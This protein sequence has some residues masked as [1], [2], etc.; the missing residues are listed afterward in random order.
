MPSPDD[1]DATATAVNDPDETSP[2]ACEDSL[3][4]LE[5]IEREAKGQRLDLAAGPTRLGRYVLLREIGAGAIGVVYAAYHE[6]LDRKLA[7]KVLNRQRAG[8]VDLEA[9]LQREARALAKLSHP[10][11]VQVYDVGKFEGR[12]FVAME[13]VEGETLS[14]WLRR[15]NTLAEKLAMFIAAGRGL[16][17]AHQAG[18]VH[19]DFK[20]DNVLV[21]HDG[22]PRVLDFGLARA[23]EYIPPPRPVQSTPRQTTGAL[24][25]IAQFL[26]TGPVAALRSSRTGASDPE[27]TV[28]SPEPRL[29]RPVPLPKELPEGNLATADP[30]ADAA[31]D[32]SRVLA[33]GEDVHAAETQVDGDPEY[34]ATIMSEPGLHISVAADN[35]SVV[36]D[37]VTRDGALLG[38][39]AYMSPEQFLGQRVDHFSD[40]F[41]FCVALYE[42]LYGQR[43][44]SG[45]NTMELALQTQ[46]GSV[47][48]PPPNSEVPT[49][50]RQIVLRGLSPRAANRYE[51]MEALLAELEYDPTQHRRGRWIVGIGVAAVAVLA[52]AIGTLGPKQAPA[53]PTVDTVTD[54]LWPSSRAV[55]LGEAFARSRLL[56]ANAAWTGAEQRLV[57]W[58]SAWARERVDACEAT[59]V[60]Q[61]FSAEVLDLRQACLD[62]GR[63]AFEALTEQF[64]SG[65]ATVIER[66]IE[67]AAELPDPRRCSD[68]N[69]LLTGVEA[70]PET[71]AVE[72]GD[73]R[74]HLAEI[75]M[76]GNTGRWQQGLALAEQAVE[77][78]RGTRYGP[79]LAEALLVHGRLLA[80]SR[81]GDE[82]LAALQTA[83]DEAERNAHDELVP[84]VATE[85][86]SLSIYTR[87]DPIRGRIWAR[88]AMT[89]LDRVQGD[90]HARA[91]GLRALGNIERLDGENAQAEAHL[92][93]ALELLD[94]HSAGHPDRAI[95]L[96]DLGNTLYDQGRFDA[97]GEAYE[98]ALTQSIQSFGANHPRVG[99]AHY[100]LARVALAQ[101]NFDEVRT[102]NEQ[103]R[104][105]YEAAYGP[106]HRDVGKV[107]LLAANAAVAAGELADAVVHARRVKDIYDVEFA[108]DSLD[109]AEPDLV[110]GHIAFAT[111][112]YDEALTHY[113]GCLATQRAALPPGHI[114]MA[115][116]LTNIGLVHLSLDEPDPAVDNLGEAVVLLEA[117][118]L[119]D[120]EE[121]RLARHYLGDALLARAGAGDFR[122][123]AL[124]FETAFEGCTEPPM[125]A[126]LA[127]RAARAHGLQ[128]DTAAAVRW[129]DRARPLFLTLDPKQHPEQP[130]ALAE[131][132]ELSQ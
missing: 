40:Q 116:T 5:R 73:L 13:F 131:L 71:V 112:Q 24:A 126:G 111:K 122:R 46:E 83:L 55:A 30:G 28:S 61:E 23:A 11:V 130:A 54:E 78:A 118:E 120:P 41:S 106:R 96:N 90:G 66:A 103:A 98:Q 16:A 34:A 45:K 53:C 70:P 6:E 59:H 48:D 97:A 43:P 47:A 33:T 7:I 85:L 17:A 38:T 84:R 4:G 1:I 68:V 60:R 67:A 65:E 69:A 89:A 12:V 72:V 95:M 19:R 109:R 26:N 87:P 94:E 108:P 115:L 62:R 50:L 81:A 107:E 77:Q 49:R 76:L 2:D 82:A 3:G 129:A 56:Y 21:G 132:D 14:D 20:P 63:R 9:R 91:R 57:A 101:A 35:N 52:F 99:H 37:V 124:Q 31:L 27:R 121:L 113:R 123:A 114:Q 25:S 44:F 8:R 88:R 29:L 80:E 36:D 64:A 79:V 75:E 42:A 92:R 105:I 100:N 93:E 15:D 51:S 102:Q 10:N 86:A 74:E 22:R 117:G 119:V 104:T 18:V 58:T 125:C 32:D 127:L 128:H 39:P 110:L